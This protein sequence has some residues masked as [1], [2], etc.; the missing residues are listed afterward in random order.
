MV[1]FDW[2]EIGKRCSQGRRSFWMRL[3]VDPDSVRTWPD[4]DV[5][6][7]ANPSNVRGI[8]LKADFE[9]GSQGLLQ[10]RY[11]RIEPSNPQFEGL[12]D[13]FLTASYGATT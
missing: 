10:A 11:V 6:V 13:L 5:W 2:L 3:D 9:L 12:L 8:E 7:L 1:A 4:G